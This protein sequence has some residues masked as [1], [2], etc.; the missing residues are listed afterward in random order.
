MRKRLCAVAL[1]AMRN[2]A[3]REFRVDEMAAGLPLSIRHGLEA[4]RE[5][6]TEEPKGLCFGHISPGTRDSRPL[7]VDR[8]DGDYRCRS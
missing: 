1:V 4:S 6:D 5:P 7:L 2:S 3:P 8:N